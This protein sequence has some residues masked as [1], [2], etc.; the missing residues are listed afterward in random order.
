MKCFEYDP[1]GQYN[2]TFLDTIYTTSIVF[3]YDFD[4][5]YDDSDIITLKKVL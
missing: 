5:G 2:K 1:C 4:W 3:S